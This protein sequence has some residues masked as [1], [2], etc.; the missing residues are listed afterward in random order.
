MFL[1]GH[2]DG[3]MSALGVAEG[4]IFGHYE[5]VF[6]CVQCFFV[7]LHCLFSVLQYYKLSLKMF[8]RFPGHPRLPFRAIKY[9]TS[10]DHT[11]QV[12]CTRRDVC[13]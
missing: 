3:L 1:E 8:P 2:Q 10:K 9:H 4:N 11:P 13:K 7:E 6:S 5:S 12:L